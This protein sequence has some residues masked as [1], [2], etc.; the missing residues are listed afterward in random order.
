MKDRMIA[1]L[2]RFARSIYA[3]IATRNL[4]WVIVLLGIVRTALGLQAYPPAYAA[5]AFDYYLYA[6][7]L[8]GTTELALMAH[9]VSPLY[10]YLMHLSYNVLGSAYWLLV[11]QIF[12]AVSITPLFYLALRP[13]QP[14]FAA[15]ASLIILFDM[16]F[17]IQFNF[18]AS[19]ALYVY[20]LALLFFVCLR[21]W[22]ANQT[23][24]IA[25][26]QTGF[27]LSGL[28]LVAL[29]LTRPPAKVLF[30]P[31]LLL[32][33]LSTVSWANLWRASAG[34]LVGCLLFAGISFVMVGQVEGLTS[35]LGMLRRAAAE[36]SDDAATANSVQR[37]GEGGELGTFLT[38]QAEL[39]SRN[40]SQV[41]QSTIGGMLQ[42]LSMSGQQW[43][44]VSTR[45]SEVQCENYPHPA[46]FDNW[47]TA[48]VVDKDFDPLPA[49]DEVAALL[50]S[51]R[52]P[53]RDALC[54]ESGWQ[55]ERV[56]AAVDWIA[57]RYRSLGRPAPQVLLWYGGVLLLSVF[58]PALR[59]FLPIVLFAGLLLFYHASISA[60]LLDV[61]AR[62]VVVTNPFRAILLSLLVFMLPYGLYHYIAHRRKA[63]A[64]E[65]PADV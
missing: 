58:L 25:A 29:L 31:V 61:Q 37:P 14:F 22:H 4:V 49:T 7:R 47:I 50:R 63:D 60:V 54:P 30:I 38:T 39:Y 11:L 1:M 6:M 45:P 52:P 46:D 41:V 3:L 55:S 9:H 57:L 42:Y 13:Y 65:H 18:L 40:L 19:E 28:I 16:Q 51:L 64:S 62:Y 2:W 34:F 27:F 43:G 15:L 53:F 17:H 59:R 21:A 48:E 32:I 10:S 26:A 36:I 35:G 44:F 24:M 33:G 20:L 5:D 23:G 8:N 56:Q 12:F